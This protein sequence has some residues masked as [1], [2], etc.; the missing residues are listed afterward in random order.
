M[1]SA[2]NFGHPEKRPKSLRLPQFLKEQ[3]LFLVYVIL[4]MFQ[5]L[6]K[7]YN[8]LSNIKN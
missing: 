5:I 8:K 1:R 4:Y 6:D 3:Y 2:F 7:K